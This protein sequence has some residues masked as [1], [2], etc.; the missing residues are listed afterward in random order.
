MTIRSEVRLISWFTVNKLQMSTQLVC[1][2]VCLFVLWFAPASAVD[3]LEADEDMVDYYSSASIAQLRQESLDLMASGYHAE[4]VV[5][6]QQLQGIIHRVH[7]VNSLE[8]T[9]SLLWLIESYTA[10]NQIEEVDRQHQFLFGLAE[11]S[12]DE[13]DPR[14]QYARLRLASWY[15]RS[16]RY[17]P[18][19]SLY[20]DISKW[21]ELDLP[22]HA[23]ERNDVLL[24]A[25]RREALTR[26]V[27]GICCASKPLR[28]ARDLVKESDNFDF[29]DK[30]MA[31]QDYLNILMLERRPKDA[32]PFLQSLAQEQN[33]VPPTLLG[34]PRPSDMASVIQGL[35]YQRDEGVRPYYPAVTENDL[36]TE[37]TQHFPSVLGY[38]M[39]MCGMHFQK[40]LG[41]DRREG[42][43]ELYIDVSLRVNSSGNARDIE[44]TGTANSKIRRYIKYA[45][46]K[47][48]F[49]PGITATGE[50]DPTRYEFRQVFTPPETI[51]GEGV[52]SWNRLLASHTCQLTIR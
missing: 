44:M 19:L 20:K 26:Y 47:S 33:G 42:L 6:I 45:L 14:L 49:R 3:V 51:Q 37:P 29:E 4:A 24:H 31:Q 23:E 43:A 5:A 34:F 41:G 15:L 22:Q 39:P 18:A 52:G 32:L 30:Q 48:R 16:T 35:I 17:R 11:R 21:A 9:Q 25:L 7:G 50:I 1:L 38:P 12:F 8:Q 27:A 40:L 36:R 13:K 10:L 28:R 2:V 46:R